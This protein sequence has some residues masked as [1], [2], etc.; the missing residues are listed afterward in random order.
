MAKNELI[1]EE[2]VASGL[3]ALQ[4]RRC[5]VDAFDKDH[6]A[7]L[8]KTGTQI[9]CSGK[10]TRGIYVRIVVRYGRVSTMRARLFKL[11]LHFSPI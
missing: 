5:A 6:C 1:P 3:C 9:L 10:R 4:M 8:S 11:N 2:R 7:V